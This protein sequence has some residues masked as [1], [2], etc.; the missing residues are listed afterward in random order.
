VRLKDNV[1]FYPKSF[2]LDF[3]GEVNSNTVV[4][5]GQDDKLIL[6]D[7]G[8]ESRLDDLKE[9]IKADGLSPQDVSLIVLT[10]FHPDH[11]EGAT[12]LAEDTG[13]DVLLSEKDIDFLEKI[14][15]VFFTKTKD[16]Y[17]DVPL[18]CPQKSLLKPL[19]SGPMK[20]GGREFRLY[21]T[22]G[23]SPGGM[24]FHWPER[25][26]LVT[27][28]VYFLGTIGLIK[29]PGGVPSDMYQSVRTLSGLMDVD[30]VLCGHGKPVV[31][32]EAVVDNYKAL[33][34]EIDEKIAKGIV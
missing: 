27:G 11:V 14:G 6:I 22:P 33:F 15:H 31:G 2:D 32:R 21:D 26:L 23:H 25:D 5:T 17:R 9:A 10:H 12:K 7:P 29:L 34:E 19:F 3:V 8:L 13:S 1:Y 4:I 28:D 16:G 30:L 18:R 24:C 20:W